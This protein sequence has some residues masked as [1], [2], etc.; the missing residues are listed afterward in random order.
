MKDSSSVMQLQRLVIPWFPWSGQ[1][2]SH[3]ST[4][5]IP[6][7]LHSETSTFFYHVKCFMGS[8]RVTKEFT[9]D[10][11]KSTETMWAVYTL[12]HFSVPNVQWLQALLLHSITVFL[13]ALKYCWAKKLPKLCCFLPFPPL[14]QCSTHWGQQAESWQLPFIIFFKLCNDFFQIA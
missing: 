9:R 11:L 7:H 8:C 13:C 4:D 3:V 1:Y 10:L 14:F 6:I 12:L 2:I 5:W